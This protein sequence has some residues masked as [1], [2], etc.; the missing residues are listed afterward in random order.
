[1]PLLSYLAPSAPATRQLAT[2]DEPFLRPEIG[3]TPKWY[4][5]AL[6]INFG[7]QWHTD[8]SFRR[9]AAL[10]MRLELKRKFPDTAIGQLRAEKESIDLLTGTFGACT[11]AGIYGIPIIYFNDKWPVCA[12]QYLSDEALDLLRP[13][14]LDNNEFFKTLLNQ[15]QWIIEQEGKAIGYI[16]WQGVLNNAFRLR[17]ENIF[18]DMA[19][20]PNRAHHLFEC[21]ATTMIDAAQRLYRIQRHSGFVVNF[22]TVSN[23]LVNTVS[24]EYYMNYLLP[25]DKQIAETFGCI[26]IH[27]CSWNAD[28]YLDAYSSIPNVAYIDMGMRSNLA[29]ARKLFP[30]ARRAIMYTP[31]DLANKSLEA[32]KQDFTKIAEDCGPCDIVLADMEAGTPDERILQVTKICEKISDNLK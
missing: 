15:V 6:G 3:F 20:N 13:P 9:E 5:Q 11:I 25:Y 7:E 32:I 12:H 2:G 26:G 21:V 4:Y 14:D 27:N 23:C 17:G 18:L 30:E 8:P 16:N 24:A 31:M 19:T 29:L 22:F 28:P 10:A 1:M